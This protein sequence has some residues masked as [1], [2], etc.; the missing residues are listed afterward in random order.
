MAAS[1]PSSRP[2]PTAQ[3]AAN[4]AVATTS[5]LYHPTPSQTPRP[6]LQARPP[7]APTPDFSRLAKTSNILPQTP[8]VPLQA[9]TANSSPAYMDFSLPG[10]SPNASVISATPTTPNVPQVPDWFATLPASTQATLIASWV[11][12]TMTTQVGPEWDF[13]TDLH[14]DDEIQGPPAGHQSFRHLEAF[15]DED[16]LGLGGGDDDDTSAEPD[17][18][19]APEN[20]DDEQAPAAVSTLKCTMR[21]IE[22]SFNQKRKR[23]ARP[24]SSPAEDEEEEGKAPEE[25]GSA[26][27][28]VP[29]KKKKK[30]RSITALPAVHQEICEAAFDKLKI[31]LTH[32]T[33][34]P[35]ANG[36][37]S[38]PRTDEFSELIVGVFMDAA[39][40]LEYPDATPSAEDIALIRSRVP[41]FRSGVKLTARSFVATQYGLVDLMTLENPTTETINAQMEKNRARV[42]HLMKTFIYKDPDNI[43][44]ETM[45]R[46]V[47]FQYILTTY[48]FGIKDNNRA[49]YF[50]NMTQVELVTLALII[51]A[52][53]CAIE[54]WSTGR[55]ENK[56]FTHREYFKTYKSTLNSLRKWQAHSEK[57][58]TEHGAARNMTVEVQ[59]ELLRTARAAFNQS[60]ERAEEEEEL[61]LFSLDEMFAL[62]D[63]SAGS[64]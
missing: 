62:A 41:Q 23:R 61:D 31:E 64:V 14:S 25:E 3:G 10:S 56:E 57:Q 27:V 52:V 60:P 42:K 16:T 59:Q 45:F 55:W 38:G 33:P 26:G 47:I 44:P 50:K 34:F 4:G 30:S 9:V 43:G 32:N 36:K 48:W 22:P 2:P 12:P 19:Q 58:V 21:S 13:G 63:A 6:S 54:E 53:L 17:W 46:H 51:V 7:A 11:P 28:D 39:F 24:Q 49:F 1:R 15:P 37:R 35:A 5:G 18:N 40:D 29:A 20:E 8:R